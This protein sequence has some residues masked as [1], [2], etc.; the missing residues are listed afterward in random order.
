MRCFDF[1][2][3]N[4][5]FLC[6]FL[7]T[8]KELVAQMS[9]FGISYFN[10]SVISH[11]SICNLLQA[12]SLSS[13]R[14]LKFLTLVLYFGKIRDR[15]MWILIS[16]VN[17]STLFIC[18]VPFQIFSWPHKFYKPRIS[19]IPIVSTH[20]FTLDKL[21]KLMHT[22]SNKNYKSFLKLVHIL[23]FY[24]RCQIHKLA[25]SQIRQKIFI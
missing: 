1:N 18:M 21:G 9:L 14:N 13:I 10:S 3:Y 24:A 25:E 23:S 5:H 11:V 17:V 15:S 2:S 7:Q 6:N 19:Q 12:K 4:L 8:N 22:S 20:E 16:D